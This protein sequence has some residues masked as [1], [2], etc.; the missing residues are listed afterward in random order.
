MEATN[1]LVRGK[2]RSVE[3]NYERTVRE[4]EAISLLSQILHSAAENSRQERRENDG[5]R[6]T[7]E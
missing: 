1:P 4:F 5:S 7:A 6:D 3:H 2:G